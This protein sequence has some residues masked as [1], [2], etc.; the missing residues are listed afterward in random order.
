MDFHAWFERPVAGAVLV[1]AV[2]A[3]AGCSGVRAGR[4]AAQRIV[5]LGDSITDGF[6]YPLLVRQALAEAHRPVPV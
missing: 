4:T 5:F 1:A 2:W 3:V 6:T